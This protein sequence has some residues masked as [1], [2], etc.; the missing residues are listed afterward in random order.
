MGGIRF[1]KER[2]KPA[3]VVVCGCGRAGFDASPLPFGL[4]TQS[5][6]QCDNSLPRSSSSHLHRLPDLLSATMPT[7]IGFALALL[8]AVALN[9]AA[10]FFPVRLY[11]HPH[12]AI[13][14]SSTR[15]R[16]ARDAKNSTN[17]RV[18]FR[19]AAGTPRPAS[20]TRPSQPHALQPLSRND[21][22]G[23]PRHSLAWI[24]L[25]M[26]YINAY[27]DLCQS[28]LFPVNPLKQTLPLNQPHSPLLFHP[29]FNPNNRRACTGP[30]PAS[31]PFNN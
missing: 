14:I 6:H 30:A 3:R 24:F 4:T 23:G 29:S 8:V 22:S 21:Q 25:H 31:S 5:T 17:T 1:R 9:Q 27:I 18:G 16:A 7:Q 13:K 28:W 26:L 15:T 11:P 10:A 12:Y 19:A 20:T 2:S